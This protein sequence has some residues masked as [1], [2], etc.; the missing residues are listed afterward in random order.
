VCFRLAHAT[1][2]VFAERR[3]PGSH[4]KRTI[5]A[6][7]LFDENEALVQRAMLKKRRGAFL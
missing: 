6:E 2:G 7:R 1:L 4:N 3:P 5:A